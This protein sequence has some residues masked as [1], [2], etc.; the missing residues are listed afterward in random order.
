MKKSALEVVMT[1]LH[2]GGKFESKAYQIS[3]G[4]HGVGVSVVNA[5]SEELDVW[6]KRDGKIWHQKYKKGIPVTG[7]E[8][9]KENVEGTGTK[10]TF[11]ADKE[12]FQDINYSYE[13]IAS[14]LRELAFL[15]KNLTIILKDERT[16]KQNIFKYEG[17]IV[18]FVEFV[19]KN[20]KPIH[21]VVYF[22]KEKNEITVEVALQYNEGYSE[23]VFSFVNNINTK[24]GGTHLTGFKTALTRAIN[25]YAKRLNSEV[26]LG[27]DDVIEGLSAVISVMMRNPQF[28]GQTKTKLGNSEVKGIVDSIVYEKMKEYLEEHPNEAKMIVE[29]CINAA[30][31]RE[32]AR[33]A[34]ELTRRK[35]ALDVSS[36]PGK[37]ADCSEEDPKICELFIVEGDS[38]GGSAKAARERKFQAIL[39]IRGKILNVEKSRLTKIFANKEITTIIAALGTGIGDEFDLSKLRYNKIILMTDADVDGSHIRTLLLTFF[40][41]YMPVLIEQGHIYIAIPPLYKLKKGKQEFYV[42]SDDEKNEML[43]KLGEGTEIQRYKGLGEMNPQQLWETTMDPERRKLVLV[44]MED[45]VLADKIFTI[46][47][48][49]DVPSRRAF[50]MK[51]AKEVVNLDV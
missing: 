29:K 13:T 42:Y 35:G 6:V 47:M 31:A 51:H 11:L 3:G 46:L 8:L 38:A 5:L 19:N 10:I 45:A 33:K 50:I 15:N 1:T 32:A 37:L 23:N 21:K 27:G 17:G 30:R 49:D 44:T 39:P 24:E 48:G 20:K 16:M 22:K 34:R 2:A 41:R 28:E 18:S 12:I 4:L 26:K 9:V 25:D 7:V 43:K 36:L 40:Y 14:R